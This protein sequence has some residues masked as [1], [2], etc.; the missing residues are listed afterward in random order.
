MESQHDNNTVP[1]ITSVESGNKYS[2]SPN[3]DSPS[4][5][6]RTQQQIEQ[7]VEHDSN[8][9]HAAIVR[10]RQAYSI[11]KAAIR[12]GRYIKIRSW[13]IKDGK[14][15]M[16]KNVNEKA[17]HYAKAT[18]VLEQQERERFTEKYSYHK[19]H[20]KTP[21]VMRVENRGGRGEE[22]VLRLKKWANALME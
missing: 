13:V 20:E 2:Q 16:A 4:S 6:L 17:L 3:I 18:A 14:D 8:E 5:E 11:S 12:R 19:Y 9:V 10:S 7:G 1:N 21:A 15:K 22:R